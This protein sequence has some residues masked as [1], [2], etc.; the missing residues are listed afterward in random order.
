MWCRL[1]VQAKGYAPGE[2]A[3]SSSP[4]VPA[5]GSKQGQA[6]DAAKKAANA[7]ANSR[8]AALGKRPGAAQAKPQCEWSTTLLQCVVW[9][10]LF[11]A[12]RQ[13]VCGGAGCASDMQLVCMPSMWLHG[14]AGTKC[15]N[16]KTC[17]PLIIASLPPLAAVPTTAKPANWLDA[18]RMA[19]SSK[20]KGQAQAV[21]APGGAQNGEGAQKEAGGE[22]A[23]NGPVKFGVLYRFNEGY[24]NAVKR[25]LI[26]HELL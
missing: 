25:P 3:G 5:A 4:P 10:V 14:G 18:M 2:A 24:T 6:Q 17:A 26:M 9:L 23:S 12:C 1:C 15:A 20:H 7:A 8:A 11:G 21:R 19:V 13:Y 16:V 22:G